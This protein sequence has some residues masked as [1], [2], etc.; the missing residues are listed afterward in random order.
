MKVEGK[1][2]KSLLESGVNERVDYF[3]KLT[4]RHPIF[5]VVSK[6]LMDA[7]L[8]DEE[9]PLILVVG[10]SRVGKTTLKRWWANHH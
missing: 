10:P 4:L 5:D 7:I 1:F 9:E 8:S 3:D 2:P 6:E